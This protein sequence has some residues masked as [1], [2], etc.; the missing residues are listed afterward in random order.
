MHIFDSIHI[1]MYSLA[2]KIPEH[3]RHVPKHVGEVQRNNK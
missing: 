2:T 1:N 3:G